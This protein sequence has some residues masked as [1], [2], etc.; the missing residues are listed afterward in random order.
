MS[1]TQS[2]YL[3]FVGGEQVPAADRDTEP[4]INPASGEQIAEVPK[5]S[6]AD[7]DA[8][9]VAGEQ[10]FEAWAALTPG[11]GS[12]PLLRLADR[13]E[14]RAE[15]FAQLEALNV[16]KPIKDAREEGAPRSR[17]LRHR[18]GRITDICTTFGAAKR[19]LAP[20]GSRLA[21]VAPLRELR[22]GGGGCP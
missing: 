10:A 15:E 16:G 13:L 9:V 22:R 8:A 4:I 20:R 17:L 3:M 19:E 5:G 6:S 14:E 18:C 7:V 11:E 12:L 21:H 2:E 1:I